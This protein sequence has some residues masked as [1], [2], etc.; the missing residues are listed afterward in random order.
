MDWS[1]DPTSNDIAHYMNEEN[2][3][4][5][6]SQHAHL[7]NSLQLPYDDSSSSE[8]TTSSLEET[9]APHKSKNFTNVTQESV[10]HDNSDTLSRKNSSYDSTTQSDDSMEENQSTIDKEEDLSVK[11]SL[12]KNHLSHSAFLYMNVS[13]SL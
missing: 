11:F 9:E 6:S 12:K 2:T 8:N 10:H 5:F 4:A 3:F 13:V 7:Q 1:L